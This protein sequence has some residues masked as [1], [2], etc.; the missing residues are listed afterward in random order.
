MSEKI[1]ETNGDLFTKL[2]F[3]SISIYSREK[4]PARSTQSPGRRRRG[5]A[6]ASAKRILRVSKAEP[7]SQP[8]KRSRCP[9]VSIFQ[10]GLLRNLISRRRH[11][12]RL[13]VP[14][15]RASSLWSVCR[16]NVADV[17]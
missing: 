14:R 1:R 6:H 4:T 11:T 12:G 13:R 17:T 2:G 9:K 10:R 3:S 8:L 15:A 7:D 5:T 16:G